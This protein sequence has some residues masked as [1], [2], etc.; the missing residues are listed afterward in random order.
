MTPERLGT[1]PIAYAALAIAALALLLSWL[2]MGDGAERF[3][4]VKIGDQDCVIGQQAD[5]DVLY[6]RAAN[7]PPTERHPI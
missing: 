4:Q 7:V 6:C 2:N 5:A 3:R 1:H